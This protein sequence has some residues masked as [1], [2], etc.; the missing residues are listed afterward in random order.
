MHMFFELYIAITKLIF[1]FDD[2]KDIGALYGELWEDIPSSERVTLQLYLPEIIS[3][4]C[5]SMSSSSWAGKRK[6]AKAIKKLCDALGESLSVHHNNILE[7]LLK[8]L[9]GR[10]WEV[11]S[12][13]I[14]LSVAY[15]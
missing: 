1:R 14:F 13:M 2:D 5:D 9:P 15:Q 12:T 10:F 11:S 3:L 7:S 8:E 4:L 6:S